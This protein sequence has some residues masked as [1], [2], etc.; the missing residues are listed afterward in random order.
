MSVELHVLYLGPKILRWPLDLWEIS[1]HV[2]AAEITALGYINYPC[3]T[4]VTYFG[5]LGT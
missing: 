5:T 1:A 2:T 3:W 4:L